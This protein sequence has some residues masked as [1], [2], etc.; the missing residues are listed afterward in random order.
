MLTKATGRDREEAANAKYRGQLKPCPFCGGNE[1]EI[2]TTH[3]E[4]W[5]VECPC[6]AE[7]R[8]SPYKK[9]VRVAVVAWNTRY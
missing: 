4:Y 5:W 6:G 2:Q 1:A 9:G 3:A 8:S 7:K